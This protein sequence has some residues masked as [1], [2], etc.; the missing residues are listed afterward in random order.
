ME[1]AAMPSPPNGIMASFKP[2][3]PSIGQPQPG[4]AGPGFPPGL[5]PTRGPIHKPHTGR[6]APGGLGNTE[7]VPFDAINMP[8]GVRSLPF[9]RK[10][11]KHFVV[12]V[13]PRQQRDQ[14]PGRRGRSE[15]GEK[16]NGEA[17]A[18]VLDAPVDLATHAEAAFDPRDVLERKLGQSREKDREAR[19][20]V[21]KKLKEHAVLDAVSTMLR[22]RR[23]VEAR[24]QGG[25]PAAD[26]FKSNKLKNSVAQI[27]GSLIRNRMGEIR[28]EFTHVQE[29]VEVGDPSLEPQ[30]GLRRELRII[31]GAPRDSEV[32]TELS[33]AVMARALQRHA[34]DCFSE[35]AD[36]ICSQMVGATLNQDNLRKNPVRN[37]GAYALAIS[38]SKCFMQ[39]RSTM[40]VARQLLVNLSEIKP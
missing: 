8:A 36:V 32:E 29:A 14:T 5:T 10:T 40:S 38:D 23:E 4:Q 3:N 19:E 26:L 28:G 34:P 22:A 1:P 11:L 18:S 25:L 7:V 27:L 30:R 12:P 9:S 35:M 6:Q 24:Q 33:V 2:F 17:A 20:E 13:Q 39:L 21:E 31:I 15:K 16:K 37:R